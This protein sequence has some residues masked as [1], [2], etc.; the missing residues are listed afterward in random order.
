[1]AEFHVPKMRSHASGQAVMTVRD[2]TNARRDIYLGKYG[3]KDA[4]EAYGHW[5]ETLQASAGKLNPES[6]RPTVSCLMRRHLA[7]A[8]THYRKRGAPTKAY[9]VLE[10]AVSWFGESPIPTQTRL[11]D[12]REEVCIQREHLLEADR[13]GLRQGGGCPMGPE[14]APARPGRGAPGRRGYRGGQGGAGPKF[15]QDHRDL[16]PEDL[17]RAKRVARGQG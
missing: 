15:A 13:P 17:E 4:R 7:W 5:C 3:T 1:M 16:H 8:E 11:P 6:P 12:P 14:S 2:A 9:S 10:R